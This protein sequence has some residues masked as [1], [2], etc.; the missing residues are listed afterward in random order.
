M[1]WLRAARCRMMGKRVDW[2]NWEG[3]AA[4]STMHGFPSAIRAH[5]RVNFGCR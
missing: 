3:L 5:L 4:I 1:E 2:Q